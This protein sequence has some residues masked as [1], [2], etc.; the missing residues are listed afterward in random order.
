[1][2]YQ[3]KIDLV[4]CVCQLEVDDSLSD[5]QQFCTQWSNIF[6]KNTFIYLFFFKGRIL[7]LKL[8]NIRFFVG[9]Q[10]KQKLKNVI[11]L[12]HSSTGNK[13]SKTEL[14]N[15]FLHILG[16]LQLLETEYNT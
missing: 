16:L 12:L 11:Q 2:F 5:F 7:F 9:L 14:V 4:V 1:M 10:V 13:N 8:L 15:Q 6:Y 3:I